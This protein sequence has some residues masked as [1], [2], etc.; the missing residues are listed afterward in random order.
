MPALESNRTALLCW[1]GSDGAVSAIRH[2]ARIL[3]AGHDAV[4][5]FAHVPTEAARGILAGFSGPDAPIMGISDAEDL[6]ERG[7]EVAREAGFNATGL[8]IVAERR[9][10]EIVI[11]LAEEHDVVLIVMG[12]RQRSPSEPCCSDRSHAT[13]SARTIVRSC[14]W[15]PEALAQSR[16]RLSGPS[17][18]GYPCGRGTSAATVRSA[19]ASASSAKVWGLSSA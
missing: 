3:G 12:Q 11:A 15:V 10:S 18:A 17:G 19:T 7:V 13:S 5:L 14:W 1:D 4:V 6:L 2:A 8:R 9:T 16:D